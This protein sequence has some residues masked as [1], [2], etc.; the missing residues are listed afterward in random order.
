MKESK[1]LIAALSQEIRINHQPIFVSTKP[2]HFPMRPE[3]YTMVLEILS[4]LGVESQ[5]SVA[6]RKE[7]NRVHEWDARFFGDSFQLISEE[8]IRDVLSD[9]PFGWI[10]FHEEIGWGYL[11]FSPPVFFDGDQ[12]ALIYASQSCGFLCGEGAWYVMERDND[13][14]T[15]V[16]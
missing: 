4:D 14:W 5:D 10:R 2:G 3:C 8:T 1:V 13:Q 11:T 15:V 12:Y 9:R 7:W 16:S 6:W